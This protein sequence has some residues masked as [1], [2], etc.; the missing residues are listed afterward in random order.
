MYC[1]AESVERYQCCQQRVAL[2]DTHC[3]A[4][5]L[6]YDD[7]AEIVDPSDYSGS[8]HIFLSPLHEYFFRAIVCSFRKNMRCGSWQKRQKSE[9]AAT[10]EEKLCE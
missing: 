2:A 6:R 4:D 7:P 9:K 10:G 1:Q 8:F 5:L 3:A